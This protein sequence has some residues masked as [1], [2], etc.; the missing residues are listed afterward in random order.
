M[1]ASHLLRGRH[2]LTPPLSCETPEKVVAK[3]KSNCEMRD[4]VRAVLALH[5]TGIG[6]NVRIVSGAIVIEPA[7]VAKPVVVS[8]EWMAA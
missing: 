4:L 5:K 8:N 1:F 3:N 7:G 6:G 2:N